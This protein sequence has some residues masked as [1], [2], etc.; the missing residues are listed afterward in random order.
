MTH[1]KIYIFLFFSFVKTHTPIISWLIPRTWQIEWTR[2]IIHKKYKIKWN[3]ARNRMFS[4]NAYV[5]TVYQ[6]NQLTLVDAKPAMPLVHLPC[7]K[8]YLETKC[9]QC[10]PARWKRTGNSIACIAVF[11]E[12]CIAF[13]IKKFGD[14]II[15][16]LYV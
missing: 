5:Y 11:D 2:K 14:W 9:V 3:S 8:N 15:S 13:I 4:R 16:H 1:W 7:T 10:S 6:K 12:L